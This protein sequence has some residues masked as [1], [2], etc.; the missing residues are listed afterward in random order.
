MSLWV[1]HSAFW[2]WQINF[3]DQKFSYTLHAKCGVSKAIIIIDSCVQSCYNIGIGIGINLCGYCMVYFC[4]SAEY[5][6]QMAKAQIIVFYIWVPAYIFAHWSSITFCINVL[7]DFRSKWPPFS[8]ILD[9]FDPSFLQNRDLLLQICRVCLSNCYGQINCISYC[10][11][12]LNDQFQHIYLHIEAAKH[13]VSMFSIFN[14]IDHLFHW[15]FDLLFLQFNLSSDWGQFF[16]LNPV[17]KILGKSPPPPPL[18]DVSLPPDPPCLL[19]VTDQ[20][21][22]SVS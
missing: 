11:L 14:P 12:Y 4:K 2:D 5:V 17:T 18:K 1:P 8:L 3:S 7:L 9:L 15:S 22:N 21:L 19:L 13:F 6:S 20:S 10:I 16:M